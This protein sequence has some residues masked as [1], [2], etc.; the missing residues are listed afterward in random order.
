[1]KHEENLLEEAL[2]PT[3]EESKE[4]EECGQPLDVNKLPWT[5][6]HDYL[7][8]R[9][10]GYAN[11]VKFGPQAGGLVSRNPFASKSQQRFM[12]AAEARGDI[13]KGTAEKWAKHTPNIKSLP[14]RAKKKK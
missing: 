11:E 3:H 9:T 12:F 4:V 10:T 1:M 6:E 8:S 7:I 13:K 2:E 5:R 14:E